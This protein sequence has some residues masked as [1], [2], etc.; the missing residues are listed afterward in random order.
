[1]TEYQRCPSAVRSRATMRDQRGSSATDGRAYVFL[2]ARVVVMSVHPLRRRRRR[3]M[4]S[5]R[6]KIVGF[7]RDLLVIADAAAQIAHPRDEAHLRNRRRGRARLWKHIIADL[8][9]LTFRLLRGS[10][11]FQAER[12]AVGVLE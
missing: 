11:K 4:G 1:M 3:A 6:R 10:V 7:E 12:L 5:V 9:D 2:F 8:S